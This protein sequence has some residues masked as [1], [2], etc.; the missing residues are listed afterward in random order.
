MLLPLQGPAGRHK[1]G[2]VVGQPGAAL[3][4]FRA[5][6]GIHMCLYIYIYVYMYISVGL[7][8]E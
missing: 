5:Y 4:H 8:R 3:H 1:V 7:H 6:V 2:P